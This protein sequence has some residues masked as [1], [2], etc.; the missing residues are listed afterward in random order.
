[1]KKDDIRRARLAQ[2]AKEKGSLKAV[3]DSIEKD[4]AY[5]GALLHGYPSKSGSRRRI[6]DAFASNL[7]RA[8]KKPEGWM[9]QPD[10]G[11]DGLSDAFAPL[12]AWE[13]TDALPP[14]DHVFI[15][16]LRARL[17]TDEGTEQAAD[18]AVR[19]APVLFDAGFI[20]DLKLNPSQL[21]VM[22]ARGNSMEPQIQ[23]GDTLVVDLSQTDVVDGRVYALSYSGGERVKRLTH[24]PGG[25]LVI[26]SDSERE[27]LLTL[28]LDEAEQVHIIGRVVYRAGHRGL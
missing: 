1:M 5:L 2:L 12:L 8:N 13:H 7:E 24:R 22:Y 26:A 23:D 6:T 10:S 17:A 25:G 19:S 4:A 11:S 9:D 15:P 18:K 21:V 28:T 3:A 16:Q 14:G 20:R 27:P